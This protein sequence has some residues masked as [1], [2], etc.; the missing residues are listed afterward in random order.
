MKNC[1]AFSSSSSVSTRKPTVSQTGFGIGALEHE[2]VVAGLLDTA[3]V[4][5]VAVLLGYDQAVHFRIEIPAA[6]RDHGW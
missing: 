1:S 6:A 2:A 3:K 5:D 4:D